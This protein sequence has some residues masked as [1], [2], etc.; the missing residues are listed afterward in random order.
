MKHFFFLI[1][2]LVPS[3]C[4]GQACQFA[5]SYSLGSTLY[6]P[7]N[8]Y[9][10]GLNCQIQKTPYYPFTMTVQYKGSDTPIRCTVA[11]GYCS[12]YAGT[13]GQAI[14]VSEG[15]TLGIKMNDPANADGATVNCMVQI[16]DTP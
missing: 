9:L 4:F 13:N 12:W 16:R 5:N 2:L 3:L 8:G 15:Y 11:G 6:V 14:A 1:L 7:R 10:A